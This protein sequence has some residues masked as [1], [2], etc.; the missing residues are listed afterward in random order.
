MIPESA[1]SFLPETS[2][3][4]SAKKSKYAWP[5]EVGKQGEIRGQVTR[6]FHR[7]PE[8]CAGTLITQD[9]AK[10]TFAGPISVAVGDFIHVIGKWIEHSKFGLQLQ[11]KEVVCDGTMD[12]D[13]LAQYLATNPRFKGLGPVRAVK[14]AKQFGAD[15][16]DALINKWHQ[17]MQVAQLTPQQFAEFKAAWDD[18]KNQ[19]SVL[20]WLAKHGLT[21]YQ[22]KTLVAEFKGNTQAVLQAN[23][24]LIMHRL[25]G[26]GFKKA[27]EI[28]RKIGVAK[29]HPDRLAA[30]VLHCLGEEIA[31][32]NTWTSADD[33]LK[34]AMKILILDDSFPVARGKVEATINSLSAEGTIA[35]VDLSCGV[36]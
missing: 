18:E 1:E 15:F 7:Q 3:N 24:Y 34:K 5:P 26:F 32:G 23:P 25:D 10:V 33:L 12:A 11:V 35:E 19:R 21:D 28:A 8:F 36:V 31:F 29:D 17:V 14:L 16:D 30:G 27:D 4:S 22:R 9:R 6:V 20:T 2:P 13:G